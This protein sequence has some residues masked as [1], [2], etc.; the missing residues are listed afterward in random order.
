MQPRGV[1]IE[2]LRADARARTRDEAPPP[3]ALD[4]EWVAIDDGS[5]L[6]SWRLN[7][8]L[9]MT[10]FRLFAVLAL[11]V[12]IG[13]GTPVP[14]TAQQHSTVVPIEREAQVIDWNAVRLHPFQVPSMPELQMGVLEDRLHETS[15]GSLG[16][17]LLVGA[18]AGIAVGFLVGWAADVAFEPGLSDL[19]F[20]HLYRVTGAGVGLVLGTAAGAVYGIRRQ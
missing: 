6:T 8:D 1:F 16:Q 3:D 2:E 9:R 18:V 11:G 13:W 12:V 17:N 10:Q 7:K 14:G 15:S 5:P 19:E 4:V 20:A